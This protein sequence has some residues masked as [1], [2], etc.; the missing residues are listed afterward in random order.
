MRCVRLR[1][2]LSRKTHDPAQLVSSFSHSSDLPDLFIL[3]FFPL[4]FSSSSFICPCRLC[5][6]SASQ[7]P[8][9]PPSSILNVHPQCVQRGY[10]QEVTVACW[11]VFHHGRYLGY[12][13]R[14]WTWR[15]HVQN[16]IS[17]R[18]LHPSPKWWAC[19]T[20]FPSHSQVQDAFQECHEVSI[21]I[22]DSSFSKPWDHPEKC[23]PVKRCHKWSMEWEFY[24]L[25]LIH[26]PT[27]CCWKAVCASE[28]VRWAPTPADYVRT[29]NDLHQGSQLA[30]LPPDTGMSVVFLVS[31]MLPASAQVYGLHLFQFS[32]QMTVA[33]R[34]VMRSRKGTRVRTKYCPRYY[35]K[36]MMMTQESQ[37]PVC[38][39]HPGRDDESNHECYPNAS[40]DEPTYIHINNN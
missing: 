4:P 29:L 15:Q 38:S 3:H 33:M 12:L 8:S 1:L 36:M 2:H 5:H 23:L 30:S 31:R 39:E 26:R 27:Q 25:V 11:C 7:C 16:Y 14:N 24:R 6:P 40:H 18:R 10:V 17:P 22:F 9:V 21:S 32:L 34:F 35:V 20:A 28:F 37:Q 19:R 13:L